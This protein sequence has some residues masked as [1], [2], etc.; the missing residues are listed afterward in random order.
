MDATEKRILELRKTLAYHSYKYYVEDSPEISD[1][2]YDRLFR[3]LQE[4]EAAHP[5]YEDENSPT[6]R[7]GGQALDKFEKV[8]HTLP[9]GS[10]TDVFDF[11]EL[12][13]FL[14]SAGEE[15]EYSVE[16]KI[17][18]LSVALRYENGKFVRGATRGDGVVG[19]DVTR[20]LRTVKSIPLTIPYT[21][22]LEVRGEVY[23]P[24][25]RFEKLNAAR[26]EKGES[27]FANP[28]NAAAG[29]LRQLDS[30]IT[31]ER[32]LDIFVFNLQVC[33]RA[34]T[35]HDESLAFLAEQG[36]K[37]IPLIETVRG[38]EAIVE[39]IKKIGELR[40][41]LPYDIDGAVVK[42]N[43]LSTRQRLGQTANTPK[44]AVAYKYPPERKATKLTD[45]V[46]QVGRTGV[47]TP[48]AV[49]SPVRLAGTTVSR[50][51][52]HNLSYI[53]ERDIRVGDTVWV[54]KAGDIIPEIVAV[55]RDRRT[56]EEREY[57]PPTRCPSCGEPVVSD[58]GEAALRCTNSACP[59]QL[60]RTVG[61]FASRG[62]MNIDGLGESLVAQLCGSG[63]VKNAAD[64]YS[65][66]AETLASLD[67]MGE[68][69]ASN[70]VAAIEASKTRGPERLLSALGIR[71]VGEKAAKAIVRRYP[72]LEELFSAT[73]EDLTQIDDVGEITAQ[74][75]VDFFAHPQ[76][77]Q[78]IN[79]MKEKGVV[80]AK[81][82]PA[83]GERLPL[84]GLTFV[85]TGTLPTLKREEASELIEKHGGK[86]SS[87]VSKKTSYVVAGAEA[88]S[89]L[90][91]AELLGVPVLSEEELLSMIKDGEQAL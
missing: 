12:R 58:P 3:E 64:L 15:E 45:I 43:L 39:R 60:V 83:A 91:K 14:A 33:D 20:N 76:T 5:E 86:T 44:W 17:D 70:L 35:K 24:K 47:L 61:Y 9:L 66:T 29:S 49:L 23:M 85:L 52:L 11:E 75:I 1:Y 19:E 25:N 36:F 55:D 56:G 16:A 22:T 26:E 72:D 90:S 37:I 67:R 7:V 34:F 38:Y 10:L 62:A 4:L 65:L 30:K 2:E 8:T 81:A 74:S 6:K 88:G 68:K 78:M 40:A 41:T 13:A 79:A 87:S 77:R 84:A 21:G 71:Q 57:L 46:V 73:V 48:N 69:S 42:A 27:L 18:G 63:L 51:T 50:A 32:G 82:S 80:T 89:K 54:Q 59:A 53:K 28:R 31:A